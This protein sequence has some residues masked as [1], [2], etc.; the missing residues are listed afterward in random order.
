M[1]LVTL[2]EAVSVCHTRLRDEE[3]VVVT[4]DMANFG[5]TS[6]LTLG[7]GVRANVE[8]SSKESEPV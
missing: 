2:S 4:V 3:E 6:W 8:E 7:D 1:L 5:G